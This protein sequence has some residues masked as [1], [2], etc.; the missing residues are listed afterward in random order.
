MS[1]SRYPGVGLLGP[2]CRGH[3]IVCQFGYR[4]LL[5]KP[6]DKPHDPLLNTPNMTLWVSATFGEQ[7]LV[8][9]H[10]W[11]NSPELLNL[12]YCYLHNDTY[13]A[14]QQSESE[15]ISTIA[16]A[17]EQRSLLVIPLDSE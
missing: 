10:S 13:A 3:E 2:F 7:F 4:H 14:I 16:I 17:L 8:N 6:V 12:I 9:R 15:M 11:K 1:L 5:C